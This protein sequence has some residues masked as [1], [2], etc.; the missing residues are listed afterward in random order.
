MKD[1][2]ITALAM[3]AW[4]AACLISTLGP[5][6]IT[7]L[8]FGL[9]IPGLILE[10]TRHGARRTAESIIDV[11]TWPSLILGVVAGV[12]EILAKAWA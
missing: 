5:A 9:A 12:C 4:L 6:V 3:V 10:A 11:V 7:A 1:D 2:Q 8:V